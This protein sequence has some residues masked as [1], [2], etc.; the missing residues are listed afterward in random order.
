MTQVNTAPPRDPVDAM[1]L[2]L[3]D[4]MCGDDDYEDQQHQL[5][6]RHLARGALEAASPVVSRE[7]KSEHR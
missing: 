6:F 2:W 3:H 5:W 1:A 4:E 7:T